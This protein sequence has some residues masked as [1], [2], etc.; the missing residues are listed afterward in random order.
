MDAWTV[1]GFG[2]RAKLGQ[3][4]AQGAVRLSGYVAH[5]MIGD[6]M[7]SGNMWYHVGTAWELCG[8]VLSVWRAPCEA[9]ARVA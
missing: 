1:D 4:A 2:L 7:I 6:N 3:V 5:I 8:V 9:G